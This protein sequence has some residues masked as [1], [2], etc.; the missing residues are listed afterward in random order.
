MLATGALLRRWRWLCTFR[1][2]SNWRRRCCPDLAAFPAFSAAPVS[3]KSAATTTSAIK[4][5]RAAAMAVRQQ[6]S[7]PSQRQARARVKMRQGAK[8]NRRERMA[9]LKIGP[10]VLFLL[11]RMP[12][13]LLFFL[14]AVVSG[15]LLAGSVM[16]RMEAREEHGPCWRLQIVLVDDFLFMFRH[17][18][19]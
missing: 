16:C 14:N 4:H 8:A 13:P 3:R 15:A 18:F 6:S 5:A 9:H 1:C 17:W 10:L 11:P 12:R 7:A 19:Y 2:W